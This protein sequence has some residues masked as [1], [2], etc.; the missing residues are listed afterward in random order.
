MA[1][2][3]AS[4]AVKWAI[5]KLSSLLTPVRQT[6]VA[7]SSSSSSSSQGL[8]DLRMLERTMRRI[9]ATL[10]DAEEHWNIREESAK[11]RLRELKE[12]AYGAEDVVEEYE[13][14]V[15]RCRLEAADRCASNCSKRKRHEVNDEQF[16]QF[17][18][19][20]VPH[21]LVVR[22]RELIQRFDEMKVY[23][24]HFSM[25]DND[26]ER[27]IVPDIHSVRP[28]SYL[29]DK[30]S[31]IG[32]ELDKKTIIEKLMSGHGNNAVSDYL[33]V[34]AI[35]GMGG[36]GK[37]TLAQLVYND[38]TVHRSYD[39]CVWVYVSDHF[40]STN[41]TKKII[42]SITKESNNLSELVDLQ[43]KLGQ[44]I[45]GKRF[46]LV[47]D[48]V[49]NERKDCWETFCKP[50][51]A[52]RQCNILVT[53]RNVAVARLVQTMPH[54]TIDHLSP[55][56]SWTL[57]ERTVAVHD[58]IIQGNLVDIA[59]KIVQKC[60][61]LPLAI[62]TLGSMLRYES[63]ESRWID[64]LESE[65]WD[66]DKA[67]NEILPALELS[68]KNMPMHLKLCFV[69]LCLFPKD[70]S[71]KKSEVISLWGLLDI[72]QCDEWN[73]E[74]ESG[75]QYF[76]FGRTGSRYYDELVQ[77]S[78]LQISF[79]SGIMHD[80]IHD[81]ACHLSGNEFFRLEGDK[82]VEIPQNARFMSIIDYHTSVQFSA[83]SHP[84]WAIIGLERDEV[85]NLELLFSICKNLRVL[86]L[87]DRN[88]H[89]ALPR[90][91]SSMKLLRHLEGPWN[92]P[93]GI[94][95]LINLHTF[96]HVYICRCGGSFNL[97]EL[98][99]LNKKKGKLR[100]SGLGN[101]S[102]V[103]DAIEAQLMNKKHLQFLQL[104][105]SEVE[106]LH[107]PLQLGLNFTPK[108]VRY[109][110]LQYQYMQQPKYPIVPHNQIL[111]SL[112]PH[113]G[114]RRLAIYGYKCQ[115]YPS[116]LGDA[117]F[118]KLTNIVLYGTDKVTQQCV[119]TLGELPFLKYVSIGR[120]YYME[121]IGREFCTRIPG[122]KGFPSLK[123]LEFSNMLHWSKWSGVDDGD[124]PCLSSLIISD[125]NRLS[126]L[127][128][129]RFSSLHYLKLSN[130]NV[131]GVI[132]AGG[133]LRDLEIRVCN[134]LHTIRTQPALLIMWLYDCPKL[135]AV[136]TMP[137]LNKL[138][139]QKCPNLTSVG[140]LP[141]LT[142][143][144]AE[145]NLADVMLF[146]QLDHLPLLHYLSIWYNTLMDNPTIP[147]LHNLKELDIHSCPGI[148]KLPFLPSLL[149]LRICRCPDLDVI[150][151]LPSLNTFHLWDP[152]LKDKVLCRLL[153]GIDH[154]WLNC[155]SILCETM[156]NLSLE[157][158][159]LSSLRK[160]LLSCANLQYCDGLSG[161]TFLEEIKIWRCP[162]LPIH[163]LLPRQLQS[164]L[165][166]RDAPAS[167]ID[168]FDGDM[169]DFE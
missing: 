15:N 38:Q 84:L 41:L 56:E 12:L 111:E 48:D 79:N 3:F 61:R 144:N 82:P 91:I 25:S 47:L 74:D 88:L 152:L 151:S 159:R 72:L 130:C 164:A 95:P 126:S 161:L 73:N 147:V 142:T 162:K 19:V 118:S 59:K 20:P 98:K 127:P 154:P 89:E 150:G 30:E 35:V 87:S 135:G 52:A 85:T 51:S 26:G 62:K 93:S 99:N 55:H 120:M 146:G 21:E 90:Y 69:S 22:A 75:S 105:F 153:N 36:L 124:F 97:R 64:V 29:V 86:A 27:R 46:L 155:I 44:E 156:T 43:D 14:E 71:L 100:I 7:S 114:L 37:T 6:P 132:P 160:I 125:C 58:N 133:T 96:P 80:L 11:L 33:S 18:L 70:Y 141:E 157:P 53:T 16:A 128:S 50:L 68:Y 143:L 145:G 63:D 49:W 139:I 77:R 110:N 13:Y 39:V 34:L 169:W 78:F 57:F 102:H 131:I 2:L 28:T 116:W 107:M 40:D 32:R 106:C 168:D 23:Y 10:M 108:E 121:H 137:K 122:N 134:G 119:P 148:T 76:L 158:K 67:H 140:S 4:M 42:V 117:S 92:A 83:S 60:D 123:T 136:G 104:D 113:E 9:H 129:D 109:E 17:G 31:I 112:R 101:L 165:D 24:K 66:L 5:D 103:Q 166:L 163:S 115:S 94:Y 8:D 138:D 1:G 65:L 45:R 167:F 81:L 149:K 54:F